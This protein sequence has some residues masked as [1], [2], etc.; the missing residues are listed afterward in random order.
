MTIRGMMEDRAFHEEILRNLNP[1]HVNERWSQVRHLGNVASV[2]LEIGELLYSLIRSLKP[3][4][5]LET[6]TNR[7]FSGAMI[8]QALRANNHGHLYT[9]DVK[10]YGAASLFNRFNLSGRITCLTG[11][12]VPAIQK[13]RYKLK[14]VDFLWL[15]SGHDVATVLG[16]FEAALPLLKPGSY[17]AFHDAGHIAT[18][19][20]AVKEIRRRYPAWE[21]IRFSSSR[22][23]DLMRFQQGG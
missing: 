7:G 8:A 22:G 2:E 23:L 13:L 10:D 5:V 17:V 4:V 18:E 14:A 1:D 21:Y 19:E 3:E 9:V 12:S 6:G 20:Q 15:D 11:W 16:E